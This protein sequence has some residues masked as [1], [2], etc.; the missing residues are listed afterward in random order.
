MPS[1]HHLMTPDHQARSPSRRRLVL[2]GAALT[3]LLLSGCGFKLRGPQRLDFAT[4]HINT[5]ELTEFGASLRRLI[6]QNPA[7]HLR[8]HQG[9]CLVGNRDSPDARP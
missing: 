6:R 7:I 3:G 9:R 8:Q 2:G 4:V 1:H 5:S